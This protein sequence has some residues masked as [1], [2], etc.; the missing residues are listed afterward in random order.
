MIDTVF[1]EDIIWLANGD[2]PPSDLADTSAEIFSKEK[3]GKR[4]RKTTKV[5]AATAA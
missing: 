2:L 5:R 1:S 3:R 4:T